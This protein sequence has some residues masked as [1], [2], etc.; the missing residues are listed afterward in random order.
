ML[1]YRL[2]AESNREGNKIQDDFRLFLV[3][4]EQETNIIRKKSDISREK[5]KLFF[6]GA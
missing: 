6:V 5:V 3:V 1:E 4:E 2:E